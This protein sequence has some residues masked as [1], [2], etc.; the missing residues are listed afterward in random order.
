MAAHVREEHPDVAVRRRERAPIEQRC[1]H[2][3]EDFQHRTVKAFST[4]MLACSKAKKSKGVDGAVEHD[5]GE[6]NAMEDLCL[7]ADDPVARFAEALRQRN[8]AQ[9]HFR[10]TLHDT[11]HDKRLSSALRYREAR[12]ALHGGYV[13]IDDGVA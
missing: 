4:H 1:E 13:E 9:E 5:E 12:T 7:T 11:S 8:A 10:S 3:G 6:V 2:C